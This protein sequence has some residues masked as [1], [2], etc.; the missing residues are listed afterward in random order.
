MRQ[1]WKTNASGLENKCEMN[2]AVSR[3]GGGAQ[4]PNIY[5]ETREC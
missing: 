1:A 2:E 5:I 3:G 4:G